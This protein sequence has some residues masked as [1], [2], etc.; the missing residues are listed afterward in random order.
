MP[1]VGVLG[2]IDIACDDEFSHSEPPN[3]PA[4]GLAA[5]VDE[6]TGLGDV[7]PARYLP[8]GDEEVD[9]LTGPGDPHQR[10]GSETGVIRKAALGAELGFLRPRHEVV[11][12]LPFGGEGH[13]LP[14]EEAEPSVVEVEVGEHQEPLLAAFGQVYALGDRRAPGDAD[15]RLNLVTY[16]ATTAMLSTRPRPETVHEVSESPWSSRN[17]VPGG[18]AHVVAQPGDA[19]NETDGGLVRKESYAQQLNLGLDKDKAKHV[20]V[21]A[22]LEHSRPVHV[23]TFSD[24]GTIGNGLPVALAPMSEGA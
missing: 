20:T 5:G 19:L 23:P 17:V 8:V 14:G 9:A 3:D 1:S 10:I 21:M 4:P 12:E 24:A 11:V 22:T 18:H 16:S 13:V 6:V 2:D 15:G 7:V